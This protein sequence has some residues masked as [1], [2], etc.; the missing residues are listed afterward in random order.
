MSHTQLLE[1]NIEYLP[2]VYLTNSLKQLYQECEGL[3][4]KKIP[5]NPDHRRKR[6]RQGVAGKEH[7]LQSF[8]ERTFCDHELHQSA[9]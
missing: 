7:S 8:P 3:S 4:K 9:A 5:L 1:K 6:H 2:V